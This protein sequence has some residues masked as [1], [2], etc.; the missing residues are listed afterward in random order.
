MADPEVSLS[1]CIGCGF[2]GPER[3]DR[4]DPR[5]NDSERDCGV[6]A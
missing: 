4:V 1:V 5:P 6:V 3:K 2:K